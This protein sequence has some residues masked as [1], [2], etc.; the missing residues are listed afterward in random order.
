MGCR[1]RWACEV[2]ESPGADPTASVAFCAN[3]PPTLPDFRTT[4]PSCC[5]P[6]TS[7]R[8]SKVRKGSPADRNRRAVKRRLRS[9]RRAVRDIGRRLC[10]GQFAR[11]ARRPA[12]ASISPQILRA[13]SSRG[14]RH[15]RRN[16]ALRISDRCTRR[17]QQ[18]RDEGHR[19]RQRS[20]HPGV[21]QPVCPLPDGA[22]QADETTPVGT[23]S[24][25]DDGD[26]SAGASVAE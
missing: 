11:P 16:K 3:K 24:T 14:T 2:S 25:A 26:D 15:Q 7:T 10:H 4:S 19:H 8:R 13:R 1:P 22:T 23:R 9:Q 20:V 17:G 5:G 21:Q 12:A 6:V 18:G